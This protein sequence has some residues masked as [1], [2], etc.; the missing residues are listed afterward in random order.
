MNDSNIE[1]DLYINGKSAFEYYTN[2]VP[3][4]GETMEL[5]IDEY[6]GDFI[7]K[8]VK[9]KLFKTK[10]YESNHNIIVTYVKV[11]AESI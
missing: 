7:V 4:I 1:I 2:S 11:Y 3:R 9:H 5:E 8:D 10:V 6:Q